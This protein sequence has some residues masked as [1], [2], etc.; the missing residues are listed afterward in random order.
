MKEK[1]H[2]G[3]QCSEF[4]ALLSQAIDGTLSGERLAAFEAHGQGCQTCGPLLQEA[5]AGH[6]WLK[7]LTEVEP[8][9]DLVTN[10]LLRTSGVVTSRSHVPAGTT[11]VTWMDRLRDWAGMIYSPVVAA[12]RQPRFAMSFGMAFFTLSVSLSLAGVRLGDLRHLDLRPSAIRRNYYE[13]TGRV[14][15]YYENIRFV[16]EIQAR[17]RQFKEATAPAQTPAE[18]QNENNNDRKDKK[19][20]TSGQPEPKQERNY[21]QEGSQPIF[22]S[23]HD[24]RGPQRALVSRDGL[25]DP[26][27]VSETTY[28]RFV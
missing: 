15:K 13:T 6:G 23:L 19:N 28:R 7:S 21:S 18:P 1:E 14:V 20:N 8:P 22:A 3:M 9:A 4:D 26:P 11:T 16:Y 12:A 10:V 2:N 25:A 5:E 27:V 17:V 24:A